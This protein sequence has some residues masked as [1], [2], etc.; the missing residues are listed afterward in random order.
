MISFNEK[1]E[2]TTINFVNGTK[3]NHS[4]DFTFIMVLVYYWDDTIRYKGS[5]FNMTREGD[6]DIETRSLKF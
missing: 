1:N 5:S 2:E 3:R 6:E 4:D